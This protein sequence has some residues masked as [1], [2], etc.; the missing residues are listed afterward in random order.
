M[1]TVQHRDLDRRVLEH[2]QAVEQ[3]LALGQLAVFLNGHQR[4]VLVLA[5]LHVAVQQLAEPLANAATL[6]VSRHADTQGDGVDEQ[7]DRALHLRQFHRPPGHGN[8]EHHVAITA[9]APQGQRPGRLGEGVD[10]QLMLLRQF[11]QVCAVAF[12]ETGVAIAHHHATAVARMFT[13]ERPV[14]GDRRGP[15][16]AAQVISPPVTCLRQTTALQPADVVAIARCGGQLR[17]AAF[18]QRG[19]N[20]EEVV[21]QQ[22]AAPGIDQDV[23]VAHHEPVARLVDA[24]QAQVERR[25]IEQRETGLALGLEQ[26]LQVRLLLLRRHVTPV[27]IINRRAARFMNDLQHGL[28]DVPAER[29]TQRFVTGDHRLPGL[30]ETLRVQRAVDAVAVLHVIQPG[31]RLQQGVQQHAL[32]HR[33]QWVDVFDLA[34]R[35]RQRVELRLIQGSQREVRRRQAAAA[36]G[37]AMGD[38]C[39][40]LAKVILRQRFD[41]GGFIALGTE[42]PAQQQLAAIHLTVDAQFVG[43]RRLR[44]VGRAWRL[45]QRTEQRIVSEALIELAKVVEGDRRHRQCLHGGLAGAI[46]QVTQHAIA[47]PLVRHLPQLLLDRLDRFARCRIGSRRWRQSQRI[48]AGEPAHRAGQVDVVEQIFTAVTFKLNQCRRLP[49]PTA[50]HLGQRGQQ[51]VVDLGSVGTWRLLQQLPGT[52][53]IEAH[54][55]RLRMTILPTALRVMARQ[56]RRRTAQLALP[57]MQFFT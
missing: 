52:F 17:I 26:G 49:A 41:G 55:D 6:V 9:H 50:D 16:E 5:Q 4:Q 15:L 33:G 51:Q 43:Q 8:A 3:W 21:H 22:R 53:G 19:V 25:L 11:A 54:A 2:E 42:G 10:G 30:G 37:Q 38:Q 40:Q 56:S 46:G 36:I 35:N 23:V 7:A 39:L 27:Q 14:A 24:D 29:G 32:L 18:A 31:A 12:I 48:G 1:R 28:A 45:L 44:I 13:Q 20:V 57:H 34:W 47:Q